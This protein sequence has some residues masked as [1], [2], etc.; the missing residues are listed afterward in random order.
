[1]NRRLSVGGQPAALV[2]EDVDDPV[3]GTRARLWC[4]DMRASDWLLAHGFRTLDDLALSETVL[5]ARSPN[6]RAA[7]VLIRAAGR[8][9]KLGDLVLLPLPLPSGGRA[10]G[11]DSLRLELD[12]RHAYLDHSCSSESGYRVTGPDSAG[13]NGFVLD[14]EFASAWLKRGRARLLLHLQRLGRAA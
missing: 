10:E 4:A 13:G 5:W 3:R 11:G 14:A 8:T 1:M 6:D 7:D 12:G 2:L 9:A